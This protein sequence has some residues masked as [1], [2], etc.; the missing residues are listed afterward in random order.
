MA[1][2]WRGSFKI[3]SIKII[4]PKT[5]VFLTLHDILYVFEN[6]IKLIERAFKEETPYTIRKLEKERLLIK[7]YINL[8]LQHNNIHK[9][10]VEKQALDEKKSVFEGLFELSRKRGSFKMISGY[11]YLTI[12]LG[13]KSSPIR[14]NVITS[15]IATDISNEESSLA[16]TYPIFKSKEFNEEINSFVS[17]IE[18]IVITPKDGSFN[19]LIN[20]QKKEDKRDEK[21]IYD[22]YWLIF[23]KYIYPDSRFNIY[24]AS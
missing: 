20:I 17:Q 18:T 13:S 10:N 12:N 21:L 24:V 14:F 16:I 2:Q 23:Y 1:T 19:Y 22:D 5:K 7:Q 3:N 15:N 11:L 6:K 8:L 9:E 4:N